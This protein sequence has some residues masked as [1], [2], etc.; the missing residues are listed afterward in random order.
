LN[1]S[2]EKAPPSSSHFPSEEPGGKRKP[3]ILIAEDNPADVFLIRK[4]IEKAGIVADLHFVDD[5]EK[6]IEFFDRFDSN[7]DIVCLDL[8]LLDINLPKMRGNEV[9]QH[10][11]A[12]EKCGDSKV[13]V[14]TSSDSPDDIDVDEMNRLG[15]TGYF[16]KAS[17]FSEFMKLG[18]VVR[19]LLPQ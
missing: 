2:P 12:S 11:R 5:G 7:P 6:A 8:I 16:K 14:V 17:D 18:E 4:T 15:A 10:M 1:Q 13:L 3:Q 19:N 9:L